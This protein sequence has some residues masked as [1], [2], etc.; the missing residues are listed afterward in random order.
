[1]ALT[2]RGKQVASGFV[3]N[4]TQERAIQEGVLA[5]AKDVALEL[6][7]AWQDATNEGVRAAL[8]RVMINVGVDTDEGYFVLSRGNRSI[9]LTTVLRQTK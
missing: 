1:M 5:Y 9:R 3:P 2:E 6:V 8:E 4:V 7:F